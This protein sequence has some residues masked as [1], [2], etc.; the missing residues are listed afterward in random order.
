MFPSSL[1]ADVVFVDISRLGLGQVQGQAGYGNRRTLDSFL[2]LL[3]TQLNKS[4]SSQ[5][6]TAL[7]KLLTVKLSSRKRQ[8]SR[9]AI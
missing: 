4:N 9:G 7:Y 6:V 3:Q 5:T 8:R 1:W 2:T